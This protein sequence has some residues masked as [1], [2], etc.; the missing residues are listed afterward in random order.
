MSLSLGELDEEHQFMITP[1][2]LDETA[3]FRR[4]LARAISLPIFLL[5]LLALIF[6]WQLNSLLDA[7]QWVDH[8]DQVITQ[9]HTIQELLIDQETGLRG[10]VITGEQDFLEPYQRAQAS[11]A[12]TLGVLASLVSD[13]P[14]Q[15]E[16]IGAIQANYG[17]WLLY[18]RGLISVR[19]QGGDYA[20]IVKQRQGKRLMDAMRAQVQSL[21]RMEEQLREQRAQTVQFTTQVVIGSSI[22]GV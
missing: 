16:L 10:Y 15:Q 3:L 6:L 21:L 13:T 1:P 5:I 7:A 22:A 18:A 12:S 20:A 2:R 4:T 14:T 8:T 17:Q 11:I 9:A 19:D